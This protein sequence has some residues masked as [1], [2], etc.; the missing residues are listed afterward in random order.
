M[1]RTKKIKLE[2]TL[3]GKLEDFFGVHIEKIDDNTYHL[4]Q[5]HQIKK[6]LKDLH[7][8]QSQVKTKSIPCKT[9]TVLK[10]DTNGPPHDETFHYRS[11]IGKLSHIDRCTRL[12]ISYIVH[13]CA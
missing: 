8:E 11:V 6:V 3:E 4:H 10:R 1:S 5:G 13:Q 2:L 7:L 9:S 12:D